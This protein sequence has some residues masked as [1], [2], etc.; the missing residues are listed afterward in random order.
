V[1]I[2][3]PMHGARTSGRRCD[4]QSPLRVRHRTYRFFFLFSLLPFARRG[5]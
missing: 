4:A 3:L 1:L 2:A 5:H